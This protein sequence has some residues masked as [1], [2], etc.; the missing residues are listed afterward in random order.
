VW[1]I[2]A[3]GR[4]CLANVRRIAR[5]ASE[6]LRVTFAREPLGEA[7]RSQ[8]AAPARRR[9]LRM[10]FAVEP[11]PLDPPAPPRP[12]RASLWSLLAPEPLPRDPVPPATRRRG[13]LAALFAPERLDD[14]PP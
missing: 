1:L 9:A 4:D 8:A 6:I 10:L 13:R 2:A 12:R 7:P 3:V 11:L 5:V 14:P